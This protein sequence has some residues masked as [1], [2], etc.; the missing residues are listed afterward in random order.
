MLE[1]IKVVP[2]WFVRECQSELKG[3]LFFIQG[4]SRT[5]R[6]QREYKWVKEVGIGKESLTS[7]A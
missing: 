7:K 2:T 3:G 6:D 1:G 5:E 4:H